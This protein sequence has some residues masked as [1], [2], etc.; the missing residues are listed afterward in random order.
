MVKIKPELELLSMV[1]GSKA[2]KSG[3]AP[4]DIRITL[5]KKRQFIPLV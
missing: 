2:R 1:V 4:I 5:N 3:K